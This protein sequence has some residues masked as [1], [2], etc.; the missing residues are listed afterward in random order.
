MRLG[1]QGIVFS[2]R[3][4]RQLDSAP[5]T[6]RALPAVAA[7]VAGQAEVYFDGGVWRGADIVKALALGARACLA[8]RA[9]GYGLGAAGEAGARRAVQILHE[10]LRTTL[11]LARSSCSAPTR[12]R[13]PS[14]AF[15]TR[16]SPIRRRSRETPLCSAPRG[17]A[18]SRR[19]RSSR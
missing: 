1:A 3:G 8:G 15:S 4:G 18:G 7:A 12:S 2:N 14:P 13:Y 5:A 17:R 16:S 10:E 6:I 11:A 19:P 9:L